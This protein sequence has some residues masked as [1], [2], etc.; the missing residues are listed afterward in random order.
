MLVGAHRR[1][2]APLVLGASALS[3]VGHRHVRSRG[4]PP[5]ALGTAAIAG[6]LLMWVGAR[7]E[8]SRDAARPRLARSMDSADAPRA[9]V[10]LSTPAGVAQSVEQLTRNEQVRGSNPLSGSEGIRSGMSARERGRAALHGR[11]ADNYKGYSLVVRS[12]TPPRLIGNLLSFSPSIGASL[13]APKT[14]RMKEPPR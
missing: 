5:A 9:A 2:Q 1:L 10:T 6:V 14:R 13:K 3:V 11:K 8:R 4:R 12:G 7:F